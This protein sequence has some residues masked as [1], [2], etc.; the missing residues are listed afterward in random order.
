MCT[1]VGVRSVISLDTNPEDGFT[2]TAPFMAS[3]AYTLQPAIPAETMGPLITHY[4]IAFW[5]K[6]LEGDGRYMRYLTPGYAK[7]N[8][9]EAV[10]T[11]E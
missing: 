1:R 7:R 4:T 5:K 3:D 6:F 8:H 2:D 9:L 10:V 11:I